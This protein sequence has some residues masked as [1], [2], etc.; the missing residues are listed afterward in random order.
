MSTES[1]AVRRRI[2][3]PTIVEG[4]VFGQLTFEHDYVDRR[5]V[6]LWRESIQ[7]RIFDGPEDLTLVDLVIAWHATTGP[8]RLFAEESTSELDPACARW[9]PTLRLDL[10]PLEE[11]ELVALPGWRGT[12]IADRPAPAL[13][14]IGK[15]LC[16]AVFCRSTSFGFPPFWRIRE[17]HVV[18]VSP[19][20]AARQEQLPLGETLAE[21]FRFAVLRSKDAVVDATGR[22]FDFDT[23]AVVDL[24]PK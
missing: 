7:V 3:R 14:A 24:A 20:I 4:P 19:G 10:A 8:I 21:H 13:L 2:A 23:P 12:E 5:D 9:R 17:R 16:L 1:A 22:Y 11:V 18:E 6:P 15:D